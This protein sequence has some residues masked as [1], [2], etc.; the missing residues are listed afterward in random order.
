MAKYPLNSTAG[1]E[2]VSVH[3]HVS[4]ETEKGSSGEEPKNGSKPLLRHRAC[5]SNCIQPAIK[6]RRIKHTHMPPKQGTKTHCHSTTNQLSS[7]IWALLSPVLQPQH[8]L[9]TL[10]TCGFSQ[11]GPH[12]RHSLPPPRHKEL[13]L[14][15]KAPAASPQPKRGSLSLGGY[16]GRGWSF[17][18]DRA[19][20][21]Q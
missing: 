20:Q 1:P 18:T 4:M 16:R 13:A 19:K 15:R 2:G 12:Q 10:L 8:V 14:Q 21:R 7:N 17:G 11:R 6:N 9:T 3:S 5:T